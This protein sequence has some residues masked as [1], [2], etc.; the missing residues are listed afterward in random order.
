MPTLPASS[1]SGAPERALWRR[2]SGVAHG[3]TFDDVN[4]LRGTSYDYRVQSIDYRGRLSDPSAP[5]T[6]SY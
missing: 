6:H 1:S 4:A 3:N 5:V 2:V